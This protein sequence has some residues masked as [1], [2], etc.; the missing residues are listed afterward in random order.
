MN[1]VLYTS[2]NMK[3]TV[4]PVGAL[5]MMPS[6]SDALSCSL[7]ENIYFYHKIR[8]DQNYD[9][10]QTNVLFTLHVYLLRRTVFKLFST[11]H[12]IFSSVLWNLKFS[13]FPLFLTQR[14]F[15]LCC[16]K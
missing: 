16:Y 12:L 3:L 5:L 7:H 15:V 14:D 1:C 11:T 10:V 4:I 6:H 8:R 9:C 13:G 2:D